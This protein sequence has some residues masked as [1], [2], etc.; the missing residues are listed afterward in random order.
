MFYINHCC[1]V[2][3]ILHYPN[4]YKNQTLSSDRHI[5]QLNHNYTPIYFGHNIQSTLQ[6]TTHRGCR[7]YK[8]ASQSTLP[9]AQRLTDCLKLNIVLWECNLWAES[10]TAGCR[11]W[12]RLDYCLEKKSLL[13]WTSGLMVSLPGFHPAGQTSPCLSVN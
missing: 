5:Q 11:H 12:P 1:A 2:L 7:L 3:L 4:T 8:A 9:Q 6:Y 10:P 13:F